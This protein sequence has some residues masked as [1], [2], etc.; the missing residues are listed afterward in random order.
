MNKEGKILVIGACGQLGT[1]LVEELRKRN[2]VENVI[3]SDIADVTP[4]LEGGPFLK[5]DVLNADQV[6]KTIEDNGIVEVFHL[7]AILSAKG[8]TMPLK[9]WDINMNGLMNILEA[10]RTY[11]LK[12]F[13]P[14]SI[15]VFG[16]NTPKD[17]TPQDTVMQP[18]TVYGMSKL[19]GELWCQYY[20][21]KY[22]VDVRSIRYPG[23]I[24][25]KSLPGGGTTDYAV[26]IF[27]KAL[28]GDKFEC[29]LSEKTG[30]PMMYM[31]DAVRGTLELMD[32]DAERLTVR[33]S[34]NLS[35]MSFTPEGIFAELKKHFPEFEIEYKPDFRQ[36]IA[37]SW[38]SSIDDAQA[39]KDWDWQPEYDLSKMSEDIITNLKKISFQEA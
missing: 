36:A 9:A 38:P 16:L 29:F 25:W 3:A 30:L 7:A 12:V 10:A 33:T 37:D 8:E 24:G 23:L 17:L 13:W 5:L 34:Y 11:K 32:A 2:G 28:A 18:N 20:F 22:G 35:G 6:N 1:E 4:A 26:D 39:S 19:A 27:H 14:S 31:P 15:A 21:E